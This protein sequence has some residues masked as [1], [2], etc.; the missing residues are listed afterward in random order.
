M[1]PTTPLAE[2][3]NAPS[4]TIATTTA[5][6]PSVAPVS[7]QLVPEKGSPTAHQPDTSTT[8]P[9]HNSSPLQTPND[10]PAEEEDDEEAEEQVGYDVWPCAALSATGSMG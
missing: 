8:G 7:S 3:P 5:A 10:P 9:L 6:A 2:A 1:T 4:A